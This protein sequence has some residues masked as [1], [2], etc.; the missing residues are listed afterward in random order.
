MRVSARKTLVRA[1]M[2]H[3][4]NIRARLARSTITSAALGLAAL[5]GCSESTRP[6]P[7]PSARTQGAAPLA[8]ITVATVASP[9]A[10]EPAL[11]AP[12]SAIFPAEGGARR[13]R[14]NAPPGGAAQAESRADW[15]RVAA[16]ATPNEGAGLVTVTIAENR[17][18]GPRSGV[19]M[20]GEQPFRV[21][22]DGGRALVHPRLWLDPADVERLRGYARAD[23][24]VYA[25]LREALAEARRAYDTR[26]VK[27]TWADNGGVTFSGDVSEAYAEAFAF[28]SLLAT[29]PKERDADA[30]R[31]RA[32]LLHV[33]D[34]AQKGVKDGAPFRSTAFAY[35]DRASWWGEG[36]PLTVDWIYPYLTAEDKAK[37]RP[38][39]LR[40]EAALPKTAFAPWLLKGDDERRFRGAANNYYLAHLR[41][42]VLFSL[43]LDPQDDPPVDPGKPHEAEENSV[44]S[45][46]G[47]VKR[48]WLPPVRALFRD[49]GDAAGGLPAEGFLYGTSLGY[50][51]EALLALATSGRAGPEEQALLDGPFW[52]RF[53]DG[54]MHSMAPAPRVLPRAAY[55]G[56]VYPVAGYGD[57][58]RTW[59]IP[60]WT[61]AFASLGIYAERA[62]AVDR[63]A[64]SRWLVRN[65][66][67]G[68]AEKLGA[69]VSGIWGNSRASM[70]ILSFMLF[71]PKAPA[72]P[73]PRPKL[74]T[75]FIDRQ[76]GRVL[77]RTDWSPSASWFA[78][79]C[80]W[81]AIPHQIGDCGQLDFYRKGEWLTK[82]RSGYSQSGTIATTDY[83]NAL[84]LEND[85]IET[86][87]L[88]WFEPPINARGSQY[89]LG[90]AFGDPTFRAATGVGFAH[91]EADATPLYNR[92][93]PRR[94]ELGE[95]SSVELALRSIAWLAPDHV[96]VYDRVAS[97][98]AGR[99]ARFNLMLP[100]APTI[101]NHA[102]VSKTPSGQQIIV[103]SL[104]P[105]GATLT[106]A[107]D[108]PDNTAEG[109]TMRARLVVEDPAR[110]REARLLHV[111][112]GADA[113]RAPSPVKLLRA[114]APL[115]FEGA[116]VRGVL[117]L[118]PVSPIAAGAFKE[119]RVVVPAA[120]HGYLI[121]GLPRGAYDATRERRGN[122]VTFTLRPGS[123]LTADEAG[124]VVVGTLGP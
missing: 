37:I 53:L 42:L 79:A 86:K 2:A 7:S 11:R 43:A 111:I 95:A 55:I 70:A 78:F 13:V 46:L 60:E 52:G 23:N 71:D 124:G 103:T 73:D 38:V 85:R 1:T 30:G 25:S 49:G 62:G 24:P 83:H 67:E 110:P 10:Q 120:T 20:L 41:N 108:E 109:E 75:A 122:S 102:A 44:A 77:A 121:T 3:F 4:T 84:S 88:S 117:V 59:V 8:S 40:W 82:E 72:P 48:E 100:E 31:A 57:M 74:P 106:A 14:G 81:K 112:E 61:Y 68:G 118:F 9:A 51:E 91:A 19:V 64:A 26:F 50:L 39:F 66:V 99:F 94:G 27:G 12:Q 45:Y 65:A 92:R 90:M 21:F 5:P 80:A 114:S 6:P 29:D 119:L 116:L 36:F 15:I 69:R 33:I 104:L 97:R 93:A 56:P 28:A 34:E 107:P 96:V 47:A 87:A 32:L 113:G 76:L 123:A 22:Q 16:P 17:E 54:F 18:A 58:L 63:L 89:L 98:A 115:P 105:P 35:H 101:S